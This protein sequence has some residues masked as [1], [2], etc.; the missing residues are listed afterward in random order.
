MSTRDPND[1]EM[2]D[3]LRRLKDLETAAPL[4]N[5][6]VSRGRTRFL[7]NESIHV[8]GSGKVSGW[9]IVTGVLRVVG[10]LQMLGNMLIEGVMTLTGTMNVTGNI[11]ILPGGKLKVGGMVIDPAN[12]GSV[13]FPGG[14]TVRG[15]TGGGVTVES[16]PYAAVIANNGASLGRN[17]YG[18]SVTDSAGFRADGMPIGNPGTQY[19]AGVIY[20]NTNGQLREAS[21]F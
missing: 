13:Q 1:D 18:F 17:G 20:K 14:S 21:G 19:P 15:A 6:S 2:M 12:G 11:E 5:T 16:G 10:T 9:W 7:G 8:D 4:G 3:V